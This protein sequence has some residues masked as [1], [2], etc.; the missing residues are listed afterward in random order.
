MGGGEGEWWGGL[1]GAA[2]LRCKDEPEGAAWVSVSALRSSVG[3]SGS[4]SI[5]S[6]LARAEPA[7]PEA[8]ARLKDWE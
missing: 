5:G 7:L 6:E 1:N 3:G 4:I 2:V 8:E